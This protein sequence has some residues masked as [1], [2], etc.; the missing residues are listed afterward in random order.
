MR[1]A[2]HITS[3][4]LDDTDESDDTIEVT[5]NLILDAESVE[6]LIYRAYVANKDGLL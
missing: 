1:E 5:N 3:I 4:L 6:D 2:V